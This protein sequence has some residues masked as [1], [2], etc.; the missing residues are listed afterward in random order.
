MLDGWGDIGAERTFTHRKASN[1]FAL[2]KTYQMTN[3]FWNERNDTKLL[4]RNH[5]VLHRTKMLQLLNVDA[6][7]SGISTQGPSNHALGEWLADT[8]PCCL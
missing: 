4:E 2:L 7:G 3:K 5:L 1:C 8:K 6:L